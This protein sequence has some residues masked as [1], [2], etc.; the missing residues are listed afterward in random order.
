MLSDVVRGN[1]TEGAFWWRK[2]GLDMNETRD[3]MSHQ[4]FHN[5]NFDMVLGLT[6]A[7]KFHNGYDD[8]EYGI[9]ALGGA[10]GDGEKYG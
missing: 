3:L 10:C 1:D 2:D 4:Y 5:N 6:G 8:V 9:S 7:K